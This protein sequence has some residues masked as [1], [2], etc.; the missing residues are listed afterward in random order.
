M[1]NLYMHIANL[2]LSRQPSL[3]TLALRIVTILSETPLLLFCHEQILFA[4][5]RLVQRLSKAGDE[6][7]GLNACGR[8]DM[9]LVG[10]IAIT[11][12]GAVMQMGGVE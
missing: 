6:T 10:I 3:M 4:A 5:L 7:Y 1:D 11:L 12:T 9:S 2:F 8:S